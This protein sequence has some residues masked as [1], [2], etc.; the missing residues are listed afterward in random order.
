MFANKQEK[1]QA[2]IDQME[3]KT[4]E[5][6]KAKAAA[7]AAWRKAQHERELQR[8]EDEL[9]REK[10]AKFMEIER[11]KREREQHEKA[12]QA[13]NLRLREAYQRSLS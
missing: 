4:E 8:A 10:E 5:Q 7:D 2:K 9:A 13:E 12:T 1:S 11:N 3:A 6:R